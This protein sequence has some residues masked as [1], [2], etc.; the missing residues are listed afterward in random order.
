MTAAWQSQASISATATADPVCSKPAGTVQG[1]LLVAV[2]CCSGGGSCATPSGWNLHA[3]SISTQKPLFWKIAGASE[4]ANYTFDVSGTLINTVVVIDRYNGHD[5]TTPIDA[6]GK[7]DPGTGA[8]FV[9]GTLTSA[10]AGRLLAQICAKLANTSFTAPGTATKRWDAVTGAPISVTAGGD[11]V[12]GSGATGTR[13]WTAGAATGTGAGYMLAI[14]PAPG[15]GTFT[16]AYDFAGSGFTGQ[17]GPGEGSFSGGYA[18]AGSGF[19]GQQGP[20]EG[21][22]AGAYAFDGS[23]FQGQTG[24]GEGQFAG[25]YAFDGSS[26]VGVEGDPS[27]FG[28]FV[29][30]YDFTGGFTG[31][32]VGDDLFDITATEGGRRRFGGRK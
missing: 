10:G 31:S 8:S 27:S 13:T 25:D 21:Q 9:I 20:G 19:T 15:L 26:F 2:V 12:V 11:E 14:A 18:F 22:F 5:P 4:P 7:V 30:E 32:A 23:G 24:P 16:G 6:V 1:D 28:F 29:G 3:S 17:A